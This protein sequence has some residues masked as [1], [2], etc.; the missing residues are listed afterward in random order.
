MT[1]VVLPLLIITFLI[2]VNG[3]F[4]AAEFGIAATPRARMAQ[5]AENGSAAARRVLHILRQPDLLN[6]YISTAQV[7]ITIASLGLGMYG[8]HVVAEWLLDP[9]EHLG[10]IGVVGAHTIATVLSVAILTYL[11]VVVG[12]WSPSRWRCNRQPGQRLP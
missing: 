8:E 10:W 1:E 11:H 3:I 9:L 6:R 4:V 7:G 2:V 12:K 5:M